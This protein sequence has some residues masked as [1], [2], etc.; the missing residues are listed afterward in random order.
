MIFRY[1]II[2]AAKISHSNY[3][4]I[5]STKSSERIMRSRK[6]TRRCP[7]NST[8]VSESC[9]QIMKLFIVRVNL[10]DFDT[11]KELEMLHKSWHNGA[12]CTKHELL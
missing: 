8:W 7:R 12:V 6:L 3:A 11:E 5:T 4:C 1:L 9:L 10:D 2:S